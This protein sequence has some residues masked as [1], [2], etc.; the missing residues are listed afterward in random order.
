[1]RHA[2]ASSLFMMN[3][4]YLNWRVLKNFMSTGWQD[5]RPQGKDYLQMTVS[6]YGALTFSALQKHGRFSNITEA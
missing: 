1:M 5:L 6:G 4:N 2:P 3:E